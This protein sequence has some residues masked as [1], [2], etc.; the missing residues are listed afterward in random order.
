MA[1][2]GLTMFTAELLA[3]SEKAARDF[4]IVKN[5]ADDYARAAERERSAK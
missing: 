3:E 1:F 5:A 2:R 4:E